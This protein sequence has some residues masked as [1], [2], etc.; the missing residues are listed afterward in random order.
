MRVEGSGAPL[1]WLW[2][3]RPSASFPSGTFH[4]GRGMQSG[5]PLS[6]GKLGLPSPV[7]STG[8]P[9]GASPGRA[10]AAEPRR[11]ATTERRVDGCMIDLCGGSLVFLMCVEKGEGGF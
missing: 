1:W 11:R 4:I 7:T 2:W 10:A 6:A 9:C 3:C 5:R 8:G